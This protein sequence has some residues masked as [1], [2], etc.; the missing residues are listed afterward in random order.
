MFDVILWLYLGDVGPCGRTRT[1]NILIRSKGLYPVEL[2]TGEKGGPPG[3]S[4]EPVREHQILRW[5]I[6][7]S[8]I[9]VIL[10]GLNENQEKPN[11]SN[12]GGKDQNR[13]QNHNDHRDN[14]E[15][16]SQSN[17]DEESLDQVHD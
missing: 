11:G 1:C 3:G 7:W 8:L 6:W 13:H 10:A 14:H 17:P 9:V 5:F 16:G 2:R 12:D 4:R 15:P